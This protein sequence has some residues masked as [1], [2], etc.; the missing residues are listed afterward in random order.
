MNS[1]DMAVDRVPEHG[2]I[3]SAPVPQ[4]QTLECALRVPLAVPF[5]DVSTDVVFG[6][7]DPRP[8][9]VAGLG[10]VTFEDADHTTTRLTS[11]GVEIT[12]VC[13]SLSMGFV[14]TSVEPEEYEGVTLFVKNAGRSC[15]CIKKHWHPGG[16]GWMLALVLRLA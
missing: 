16:N 9:G 6:A 14:M 10:P 13:R 12:G 2:F 15:W 7:N 5:T 3:S 8:A 1:D 4:A 11:A